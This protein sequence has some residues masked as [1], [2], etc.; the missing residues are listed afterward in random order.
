MVLMICWA[1]CSQMWE[2]PS[3]PRPLDPLSKRLLGLSSPPQA[4]HSHLGL[5]SRLSHS[6][7]L[8]LRL[9][10]L[11]SLLSCWGLADSC[12]KTGSQSCRL[13]K[14]LHR[15]VERLGVLVLLLQV[16]QGLASSLQGL[17]SLV[18]LCLRDDFSEGHQLLQRDLI[19]LGA[20]VQSLG[21]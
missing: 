10:S 4:S 7:L 2:R 1:R 5:N 15:L 6:L 12:F 13:V 17:P 8:L 18:S 3:L 9:H 14:H 19:L 11:P 21:L 16:L 20:S